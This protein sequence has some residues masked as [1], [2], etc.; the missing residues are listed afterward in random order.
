MI[1][2]ILASSKIIVEDEKLLAARMGSLT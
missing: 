1:D 2:N